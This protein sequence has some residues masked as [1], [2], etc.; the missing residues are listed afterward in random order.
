MV[1]TQNQVLPNAENLYPFECF[2]SVPRRIGLNNNAA[3][4]GTSLDESVTRRW[5]YRS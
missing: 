4:T 1:G 5:C 2:D 3:Q